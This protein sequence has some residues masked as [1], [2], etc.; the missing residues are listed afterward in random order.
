MIAF[1]DEEGSRFPAAL[2]TSRAVAGTLDPAALDV[3]DADGVTLADH[4]DLAA[5]LTAARAAGTTLAYLE[6]HIEQGPLLEAEGFAVGTV[7]AIAAQLRYQLEV[8][9][10]AGHAGTTS[11]A[12]RRDA[13]TGAAAIVL[14]VE[15]VAHDAGGDVVA[16]VGQLDVSP[17]AANVI[18][19]RVRFTVDIRSGDATHRDAAAAAILDRFRSVAADRHLGL[20]IDRL[21][22]LPASPCDPRLMDLIDAAT[23]AAGQPV[24]RLMS[25]AG[26]RRDGDRGTVSDGDA[27]HP[28]Q[29]RRQ[30]QPGRTRR[31]G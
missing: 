8:T 2:L 24:R 18:P 30:P 5:Y 10:R 14:A 29:G 6:A 23:V 11:M 21:H 12:L 28:V 25:G 13:L 26:T 9:G 15:A 4:L 16:T 19:G 1:G 7:T 20:R 27:V 17:G 3:A 22:D 31:S